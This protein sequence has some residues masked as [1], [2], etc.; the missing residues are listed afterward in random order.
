MQEN[1]QTLKKKNL[2]KNK[3]RSSVLC[4]IQASLPCH[5]TPCHDELRPETMDQMKPSFLYVIGYFVT[6]K[7]GLGAADSGLLL[8]IRSGEYRMRFLI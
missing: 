1:T 7:V 5:P 6:N 2:F 4:H 8:W 3:G